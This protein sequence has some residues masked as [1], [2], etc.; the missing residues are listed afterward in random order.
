MVHTWEMYV[1]RSWLVTFFAFTAIYT[2]SGGVIFTPAINAMW[3]GLVG[4]A[5]S[6][7]GNEVARKLVRGRCITCMMTLSIR[8]AFGIGFSSGGSYGLAAALCLVHGG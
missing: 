1:L 2:G 7:G 6:I 3:L 8:V 4:T 5:T